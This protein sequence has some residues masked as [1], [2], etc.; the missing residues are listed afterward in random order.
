M[1]SGCTWRLYASLF[2]GVARQPIS[3][4]CDVS[5]LELS[6]RI[7]AS[8]TDLQHIHVHCQGKTLPN[9]NPLF[10]NHDTSAFI[11]LHTLRLPLTQYIPSA[12]QAAASQHRWRTPKFHQIDL[13]DT[14]AQTQ[15]T[16]THKI[17]AR[18]RYQTTSVS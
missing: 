14:S 7:E 15:P 1:G 13:S 12:Q 18:R 6:C 17:L 4:E 11:F 16:Q 3:N 2:I 5:P 9:A 8:V 10:T